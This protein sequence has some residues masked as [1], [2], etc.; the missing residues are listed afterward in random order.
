[1]IG[2]YIDKDSWL[3]LVDILECEL[4]EYIFFILDKVGVFED[5]DIIDMLNWEFD[6]GI[7]V[8]GEFYYFLE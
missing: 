4:F 6:F 1:M 2:C 3:Y 7:E 5:V 8:F